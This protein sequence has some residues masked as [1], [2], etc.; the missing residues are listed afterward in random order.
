[1]RSLKSKPPAIIRG[2]AAILG[3]EPDQ[4][5]QQIELTL[6]DLPESQPRKYF[7]PQKMDQLIASVKSKGILEPLL[8]RPKPSGRF[9]L[10]S[11]ERRFR[12]AKSLQLDSVPVVI[13]ELSDVEVLEVSLIENLQ[14]EDLNPVEEVEGVLQLLGLKLNASTKVVES[15]L[16]RMVNEHQGKVTSNVTGNDQVQDFLVAIGVTNWLSFATNK[17]PLISLPENVLIALR[18]GELAYTKAKAIARVKDEAQRQKLLKDAIAQELSLSQIKEQIT[19][20]NAANADVEEQPI[21]LKKRFDSAYQRVKK[22]RVWDDPKMKRQVEK[23][24]T[25]LEALIQD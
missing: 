2:V 13:K 17:L 12:A 18:E 25:Q 22:S 16:N 20:I 4:Q 24:V 8:V 15:I 11:G 10:V 9:E 1:V 23:L 14:R 6:I 3:D 7:D 19:A 5:S 21:S